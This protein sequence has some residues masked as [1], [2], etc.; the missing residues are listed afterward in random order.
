MKKILLTVL[1]TLFTFNVNAQ[2]EQQKNYKYNLKLSN[3][4]KEVRAFYKEVTG[5]DIT[6]QVVNIKEFPDSSQ[7]VAFCQPGNEHIPDYVS[8][9]Q[10]LLSQM[11]DDLFFQVILHEFVHCEYKIGHLQMNNFFMNDGGAPSLTKEQVKAQF[12]LF[13]SW[14]KFNSEVTA[15][16]GK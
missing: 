8:F 14:F 10:K 7:V 12:R 5:T 11:S 6:V 16:Q 13:H 4:L 15:I 2:T 3:S 1:L 9:N